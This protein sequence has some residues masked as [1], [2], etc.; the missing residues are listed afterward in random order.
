[1]DPAEDSSGGQAE[2]GETE[3][4]RLLMTN[5]ARRDEQIAEMKEQVDLVDVEK[6]CPSKCQVC[7]D[8][9][10]TSYCVTC[11]YDDKNSDK[12]AHPYL[13][14]TCYNSI[15]HPSP[16]TRDHRLNTVY[17]DSSGWFYPID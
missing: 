10:P 15:V 12:G 13:C 1:M 17:C 4:Q 7:K 11:S 3:A 16:S 8:K 2:G 9:K 5:L 6:K 14:R